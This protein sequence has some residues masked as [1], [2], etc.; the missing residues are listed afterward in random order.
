MA[1]CTR[2][3]P[4]GVGVRRVARLDQVG[5]SEGVNRLEEG[6]VAVAL[7]LWVVDGVWV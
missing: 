6:M 3:A 7:R 5:Y 2:A 1:S 4:K